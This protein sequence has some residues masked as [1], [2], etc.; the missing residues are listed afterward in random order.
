M[1]VIFEII[2]NYLW[3]SVVEWNDLG[4]CILCVFGI[5]YGK[6]YF[7]VSRYI[8]IGIECMG[9]FNFGSSSVIFKILFV[10]YCGSVWV[11]RI[12]SGELYF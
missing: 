9:R 11:V 6:F 8:I 4:C 7:E 2:D 5:G 12:G 10:G 1:I 3:W